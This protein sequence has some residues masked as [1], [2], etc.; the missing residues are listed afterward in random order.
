MGEGLLFS[1]D[2]RYGNP[3]CGPDI[4]NFR[5]GFEKAGWK[6]TM[7][8]RLSLKRSDTAREGRSHGTLPAGTTHFIDCPVTF[9][10]KFRADI[11]RL[12]SSSRTHQ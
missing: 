1:Y 12:V 4:V 11:S 9:A 6:F 2:P 8:V 7:F 10:I 3:K 5:P